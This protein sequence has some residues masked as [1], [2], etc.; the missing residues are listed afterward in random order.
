MSFAGKFYEH[1]WIPEGLIRSVRSYPERTR[2]RTV[3]QFIKYLKPDKWLSTRWISNSKLIWIQEG[4]QMHWSRDQ[5]KCIPTLSFYKRDTHRT[6]ISF[7]IWET[8]PD[9]TV[10]Q[11]VRLWFKCLSLALWLAN[12]NLGQERRLLSISLKCHY[13]LRGHPEP[14]GYEEILNFSK[15]SLYIFRLDLYVCD[16]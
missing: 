3:K 13:H 9:A 15:I 8:M 12:A 1:H 4:E 16:I 14:P 6:M 10:W 2:P 7:G 5:L 11:L